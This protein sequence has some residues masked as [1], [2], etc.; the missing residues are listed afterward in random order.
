MLVIHGAA[1][2]TIAAFLDWAHSLPDVVR[3]VCYRDIDGVR[4]SV[5]CRRQA[6]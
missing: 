1:R 5:V 2:P 3:V 4:G 6:S